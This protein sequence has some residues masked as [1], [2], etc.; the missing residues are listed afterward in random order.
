VEPGVR[1]LAD[2]VHLP[3][4]ERLKC[5]WSC[6]EDYSPVAGIGPS[7]F[8]VKLNCST[9]S[10][11]E[12]LCDCPSIA[13]LQLRFNHIEDLSPLL[14]HENLENMS[15][16][17]RGNPLTEESFYEVLPALEERAS[18]VNSINEQ[19]WKLQ[20]RMWE[21]GHSAS[22]GHIAG[23]IHNEMVVQ[24]LACRL[25][26]KVRF[27]ISPEALERELSVDGADVEAI[28]RKYWTPPYSRESCTE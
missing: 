7:L 17:V 18:Y 20:R 9:V 16:D 5:E 25:G 24:S 8:K 2:L 11:I 22:Y 4:I 12:F 10:K 3:N 23:R 13:R 15:I 27:E 26:E 14:E 28:A 1:C 6:A 21:A 19:A